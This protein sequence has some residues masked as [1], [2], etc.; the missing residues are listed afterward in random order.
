MKKI[1][2]VTV[3]M[4]VGIGFKGICLAGETPLPEK[5]QVTT[6]EKPGETTLEN[7]GQARKTA[8]YHGIV[9]KV[10]PK[11]KTIEVMKENKDLGLVFHINKETRFEGY[12][13]LS[14]IK[15][16]DRVRVEYDVKIGKS[17]AMTV[18]KEK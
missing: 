8:L 15:R 16:G 3:I 10:K 1:F 13:G 9:G 18:I 17:V 12:K 6:T 14:N 2:F 5:F 7:P 4:L 11:A